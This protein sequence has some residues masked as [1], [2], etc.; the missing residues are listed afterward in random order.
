MPDAFASF[1]RKRRLELNRTQREIAQACD[2]TPEM[3]TLM[4]SGRR[5]PDP[6]WVPY[7]ADALETDRTALCQ[8][9][10]QTWHP[11]F[12]AELKGE[13][14]QSEDLPSADPSSRVTIEIDREDADCLRSLRRLNLQA[15]R[16]LQWLAE[17][18]VNP[19]AC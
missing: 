18:M 12:Y 19:P 11:N 17:H 2:F 15:R 7:L 1:L 8:L 13:P 16:Q 5:R 3:V 6:E 9:A 10:L 14:I 4:E